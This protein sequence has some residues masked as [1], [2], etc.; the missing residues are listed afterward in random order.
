LPDPAPLH[1]NGHAFLPGAV[2]N[3]SIFLVIH[4]KLHHR[5]FHKFSSVMRYA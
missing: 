4:A 2:L 5:G 3:Q 1:P